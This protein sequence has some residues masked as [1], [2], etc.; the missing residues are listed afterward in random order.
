MIEFKYRSNVP[1]N[2][3][4]VCR[5]LDGMSILHFKNGLLHRED[6]PARILPEGCTFWYKDGKLHRENGPAVV[7]VGGSQ[8]WYLNNELHREDGPAIQYPD[9]KN[10]YYYKGKH[11]DNIP[12][13]EHWFNFI[14]PTNI[15]NASENEIS[16]NSILNLRKQ[17]AKCQEQIAQS[18]LSVLNSK[19]EQAIYEEKIANHIKTANDAIKQ[20]NEILLKQN[21]LLQEQYDL[22]IKLKNV[23]K[24]EQMPQYP[25]R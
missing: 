6:G 12:N 13:D 11:F 14:H 2:F 21:V 4:G 10:E 7:R 19:K 18:E 15:R 17:Q 20:Q 8:K 9:G 3:T 5:V 16:E 23:D 24:E 22:K 1:N 25:Y